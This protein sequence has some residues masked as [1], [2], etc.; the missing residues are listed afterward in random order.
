MKV[1]SVC[2]GVD[3][4]ERM[5]KNIFLENNL[6]LMQFGEH[7]I[8][9]SILN[10]IKLNALLSYQIHWFLYIF[11]VRCLYNPHTQSLLLFFLFFN[12]SQS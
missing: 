3:I 6:F 2:L 11:K 9:L 4:T 12:G 7:N 8:M 5:G 1:R 10:S